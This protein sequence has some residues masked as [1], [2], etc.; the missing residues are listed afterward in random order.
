[1]PRSRL[2]TILALLLI[3]VCFALLSTH[4]LQKAQETTLSFFSPLF[5]SGAFVKKQLGGLG[6]HLMTLDELEAEYHH[7]LLE[8]KR[9]HA[10]NDLLRGLEEENI[11]LRAT[12]NYRERSAF[13][14]LSA[15]VIARDH[16]V[17]WNTMKI[18][19]GSKDGVAPDMPVITDRGLVGKTTTVTDHLSVVMLVTDEECKVAVKV[20]G[21]REQGIANGLRASTGDLELCFL[22]KL[23]DLKSG[24]K[25]YTAGVSG[26]IFPSGI[27]VGTVKSF[28]VREL[29]GQAILDP[30]ADI[31]NLE[32]VF[33][34]VG[35]K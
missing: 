12:L 8:N 16:S 27:E 11:K 2:F 34:I 10:E 35:A 33:V 29:D 26:G 24:Q 9:L 31:N 20:E 32:D 7:L 5:H 1:M 22:D 15:T 23:A 28:Q 17:W 18:N 14:L 21:T 19:R 13:R 3:T 25:V 4:F 30:A 6:K